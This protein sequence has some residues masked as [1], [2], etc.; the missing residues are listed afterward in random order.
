M[1][2]TDEDIMTWAE[3]VE[4]PQPLITEGYPFSS[5]A[6]GPEDGPSADELTTSMDLGQD[7]S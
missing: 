2:L 5:T 6:E 4:T 3:K 7:D 1:T